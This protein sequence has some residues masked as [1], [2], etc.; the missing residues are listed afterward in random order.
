MDIRNKKQSS[1]GFTLIEL[2]VVIA[3]IALLASVI[4]VSVS[5]ARQKSRDAKRV[6]DL[7]QFVKGL[8]LYFN[9]NRSYPTLSTSGSL[10]TLVGDPPLIPNYLN[11]LPVAPIPADG[12]CQ[13]AVGTN[14]GN[15]YYMYANIAGAQVTTSTYVITFCLGGQTGTLS[16]GPHTLTNGGFR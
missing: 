7:N 2:L 10:S 8:E 16:G 4:V 9:T 3:V 1:A 13:Q 6:A 11:K 5:S 14:S 12:S 15:D